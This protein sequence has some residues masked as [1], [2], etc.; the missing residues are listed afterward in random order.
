MHFSP[1]PFYSQGFI[2]QEDIFLKELF[3]FNLLLYGGKDG[4]DGE[5]F[6]LSNP[7]LMSLVPIPK[8]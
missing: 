1:T 4:T 2:E 3:F 8:A 6:A 5:K 7:Y